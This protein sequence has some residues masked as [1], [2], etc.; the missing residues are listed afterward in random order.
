M[1]LNRAFGWIKDPIDR[2]DRNIRRLAPPRL[3]LPD[4]YTVY[5]DSI[6][7]DQGQTPECVAYASAGVKTDEEFLEWGKRYQFDADWLYSECK[8]IDG[9]PDQEGTYPRIAC[10]IMQKEGMKLANTSS[11]C[12]FCKTTV[13]PTPDIKWSISAYYRIDVTNTDDDIKQVVY[14]FGDVLSASNWYSNWSDKFGTFPEPNGDISGGHCYRITGWGPNGWIITNSWG[15][16][17]WGNS[18]K[19]VMSY[20]MFRKYVLPDGDVWKLIDNK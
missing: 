7:Y 1:S 6:I 3:A 11:G 8:K 5:A 4:S 9:I 15:S 19:A 12:I 17:L 14:Q 16:I 10:Q 20:D 2:R 18:G 13:V